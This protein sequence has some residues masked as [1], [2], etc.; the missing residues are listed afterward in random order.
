MQPS[1][2]WL[3]LVKQRMRGNS[4]ETLL[5][6][7]SSNCEWAWQTQLLKAC[8][9]TTP[10][11]CLKAV[12]PGLLSVFGKTLAASTLLGLTIIF[13]PHTREGC[14][15][16]RVPSLGQ[17]TG[18][19]A[20]KVPLLGPLICRSEHK[21]LCGPILVSSAGDAGCSDSGF[22][23]PEC[24]LILRSHKGCRWIWIAGRWP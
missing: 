3:R 13:D 19:M 23:D 2:W 17:A 20:T 10:G 14:V 18:C 9:F 1:A 22:K 6:N 5:L 4:G 7:L 12:L 8:F 11:V 16:E 24:W 21:C 15:C